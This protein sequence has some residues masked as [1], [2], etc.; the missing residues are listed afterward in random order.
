MPVTRPALLLV[1]QT[2]ELEWRI[3]R[4]LE[5]WAD[6]A[7]FDPS[8]VGSEP[9]REGPVLETRVAQAAEKL[10][11]LAWKSASWLAT[12][13]RHQSPPAWPAYGPRSF[14]PSF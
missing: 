2:T 13:G 11:R 14:A 7:S 12:A 8:G 3:K 9:R 10:D 4:Q 6:V 5:Q 1:P